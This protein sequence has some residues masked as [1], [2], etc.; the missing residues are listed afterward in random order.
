MQNNIIVEKYRS[1]PPHWKLLILLIILSVIGLI[2]WGVVAGGST[3][4]FLYFGKIKDWFMGLFGKTPPVVTPEVS[5][6]V[7]PP[8]ILSEDKKEETSPF[9]THRSKFTRRY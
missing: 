2:F 3:G 6:V 4:A 7:T 9:M 1:I 8:V 5:P